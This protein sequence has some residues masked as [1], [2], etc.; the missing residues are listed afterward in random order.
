MGLLDV[1]VERPGSGR[2]HRDG[3]G[4]QLGRGDGEGRVPRRTP[5][6]VE[7][8]LEQRSRM[9]AGGPVRGSSCAARPLDPVGRSSVG[10]AAE[11]PASTPP[12]PATAACLP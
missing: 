1:Q 5:G 7:T 2:Y 11:R 8:R 6:T 4:R 3:L 12:E 9:V 10:A